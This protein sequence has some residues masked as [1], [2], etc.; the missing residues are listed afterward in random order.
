MKIKLIASFCL[1][2]LT[3]F[4]IFA[5]MSNLVHVQGSKIAKGVEF[6]I[7]DGPIC[8]FPM[9]PTNSIIEEPCSCWYLGEGEGKR[10]RGLGGG[11]DALTLDREDL[12]VLPRC[13]NM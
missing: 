5:F 12:G 13:G 3:T 11:C 1:G 7:L 10:Y 4:L 8:S 2:C 9:F 6:S